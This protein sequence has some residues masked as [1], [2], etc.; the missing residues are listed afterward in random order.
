MY[1]RRS[2]VHFKNRNSFFSQ[3]DVGIQVD[4]PIVNQTYG[5]FRVLLPGGG[6]PN[7]VQGAPPFL[8]DSGMGPT[9]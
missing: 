5:Y 3:K 7:G 6:V 2:T 9:R 1:L 8:Q 4:L